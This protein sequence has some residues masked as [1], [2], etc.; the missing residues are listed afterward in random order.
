MKR[1]VLVAVLAGVLAVLGPWYSHSVIAADEKSELQALLAENKNLTL[2]LDKAEKVK[3]EI[4]KAE[5]SISGAQSAL[6]SFKQQLQRSGAGLLEEANSIDTAAQRAGCPW[7]TTSTDKPFVDSCNA[8]GERLQ[9]L[10]QDVRKKAMTLEQYG[11]KLEE[12]QTALSNK[13]VSLFKKIGRAS[14][15]ERVYVLV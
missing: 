7:G 4:A 9:S 15:R 13:T 1:D 14:C 2:Q 10:L 6:K 3:G 5:L 11:Q 12:D 8:E